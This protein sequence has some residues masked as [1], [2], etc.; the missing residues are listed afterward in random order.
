M[1]IREIAGADRSIFNQ[2]AGHPLQS[3]AWGEF[4]ELTGVKVIRKGV[5]EGK[6]LV[7]PIQATIHPLP[8][9]S[10]KIGYFPKGPMP[11]EVQLKILKQ[12]SKIRINPE[13]GKP[14]R[15]VRKNTRELYIKPFR[16]SYSYI[17]N[18]DKVIILDLY[19]KDEQ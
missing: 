3:F 11:D 4:R 15:N 8:K 9:T 1:I 18:E 5:F 12:I 16:L 2:T 17:K 7:T 6:K 13:V 19:H 10:L 14:M